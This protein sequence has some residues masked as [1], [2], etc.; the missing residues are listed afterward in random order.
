M[1]KRSLPLHFKAHS[2]RSKCPLKVEAGYICNVQKFHPDFST[3]YCL[4]TAEVTHFRIVVKF[5]SYIVTIVL[6]RGFVRKPT[7][8]TIQGPFNAS[9]NVDIHNTQYEECHETRISHVLS[10]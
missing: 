3:L 10:Y 8:F 1:F 7:F 6:I 9:R 4:L 5:V 2:W